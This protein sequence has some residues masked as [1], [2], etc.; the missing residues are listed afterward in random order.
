LYAAARRHV[1]SRGDTLSALAA[2]YRVS[3]A[4]L[5]AVN[6]IKGDKLHVGQVLR[7]PVGNEG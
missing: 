2:Q 1:I 3:L 4:A 7:I 5:R 6:S